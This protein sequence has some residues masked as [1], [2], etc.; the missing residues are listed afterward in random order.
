MA[1]R[2]VYQSMY[3]FLA[4]KS[5]FLMQTDAKLIQPREWLTRVVRQSAID[6]DEYRTEKNHP[7]ATIMGQQQAI[8]L[9]GNIY[10]I[11]QMLFAYEWNITSWWCNL[12]QCCTHN[13]RFCSFYLSMRLIDSTSYSFFSSMDPHKHTLTTTTTH[14]QLLF[15]ASVL[16]SL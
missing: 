8:I 3:I 9:N 2:I 5:V 1:I 6:G 11:A 4:H 15:V 14:L 10:V 13:I 7:T 16:A 12:G